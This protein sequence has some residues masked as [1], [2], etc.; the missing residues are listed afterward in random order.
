MSLGHAAVC[1][2]EGAF[3]VF[4]VEAVTGAGPA[5]GIE[6]GFAFGVS[7]RRDAAAGEV[8]HPKRKAEA[9][10]QTGAARIHLFF[11]RIGRGQGTLTFVMD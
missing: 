6:G 5:V 7:E 9:A 11:G 10:I 4:G 2:V 1:G 8:S 3:G